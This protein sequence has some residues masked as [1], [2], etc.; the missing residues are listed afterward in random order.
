MIVF[1]KCLASLA[2]FLATA[3]A[4]LRVSAL[5]KASLEFHA[6]A[7]FRAGWQRWEVAFFR[8]AAE[9]LV[10][11]SKSSSTSCSA[12]PLTACQAATALWLT[13]SS[14]SVLSPDRSIKS[15]A[16][17]WSVLFTPNTSL[18]R[19]LRTTWAGPLFGACPFSVEGRRMVC[20]TKAQFWSFP[21]IR[22][23]PISVRSFPL[24]SCTE[25]LRITPS[26]LLISL[27]TM[28]L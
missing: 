17:R 1:H 16:L 18:A 3:F 21:T 5:L 8:F 15:V 22:A 2:I 26:L 27:R 23:R 11:L 19:S 9:P 24:G 10:R 6:C 20:V 12:P 13:T 4:S 25:S 7:I 28:S 14:F